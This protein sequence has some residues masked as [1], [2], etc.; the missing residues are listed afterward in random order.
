MKSN[1]STLFADLMKLCAESESFYFVDQ[2]K[3]GELYRVFTYRLASFTEFQLPNAIECRGHTFRYDKWNDTWILASLPPKKFFNY[4]EHVGWGTEM[5]L[6]AMQLVMDKA[7]GSL[8]STV[9]DPNGNI[10]FKSK[11]SFTS[12][13]AVQAT[14]WATIDYE[15]MLELLN[16]ARKGYTV[17]MEW[18]SPN[19]QIVIGYSEPRL[20]VL[21]A[22]NMHTGEFMPYMEL[23]KRFGRSYMVETLDIPNDGEAFLNEVSDM[24]GIEGIVFMLADG[25][26]VKHKTNLYCSLHL[27]KSSIDSPRRLWEVCVKNGADDLRAMFASDAITIKKIS[28]MEIKASAVFNKIHKQVNDFYRA[29]LN[30]DRKSYAI[31]GQ[32]QLSKD[33]VFG[34]AMNMYIG[35]D[36]SIEDH[37]I[38]NYK[39][40]GILDSFDTIDDN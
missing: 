14:A 19:N 22:R 21:N 30:L 36:V 39:D 18:V 33:G 1:L 13:Q 3:D 40:F 24:T 37:L 29:N 12:I 9:I 4:G 11:T 34:L 5:D 10:F 20:I 2:V 28:D 17:N 23:F 31:L 26:L 35:R 25:T 15:F 7:D 32:E 27:A 38:K 8:I 16:L 6:N